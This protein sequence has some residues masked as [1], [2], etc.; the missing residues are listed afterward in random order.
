MRGIYFACSQITVS[1]HITWT[2]ASHSQPL[3]GSGHLYMGRNH[4]EAHLHVKCKW[5]HFDNYKC[6]LKKRIG[7]SVFHAKKKTTVYYDYVFLKKQRNIF[8]LTSIDSGKAK[9]CAQTVT[10]KYL[11]I[12]FLFDDWNHKF[13]SF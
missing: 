8:Q 11:N 9:A 3:W 13:L 1:K 10:V 5:E 4:V 12:G 2:W 6:L 7:V